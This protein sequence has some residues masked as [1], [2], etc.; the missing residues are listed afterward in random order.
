MHGD[1]F[2][3]LLKDSSV[4]VCCGGELRAVP[5]QA[6]TSLQISV[7]H[8]IRLIWPQPLAGLGSCYMT[9]REGIRNVSRDRIIVAVMVS[10][11]YSPPDA[12]VE[13]ESPEGDDPPF[14]AGNPVSV[15]LKATGGLWPALPCALP[16]H[17]Q[18]PPFSPT[19]MPYLPRGQEP[20]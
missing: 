7:F 3:F 8:G 18:V 16:C 20:A 9:S 1:D 10:W 2:F 17:P 11:D 14:V 4:S 12:D 15:R 6:G 5:L 13:T 19:V